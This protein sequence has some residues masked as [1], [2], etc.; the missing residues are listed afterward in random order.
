MVEEIRHYETSTPVG[1]A[2]YREGR[3]Y[4]YANFYHPTITI[5]LEI[6]HFYT[7]HPRSTL[8]SFGYHRIE[9]GKRSVIIICEGFCMRR[10][11][12]VSQQDWIW[13]RVN[14]L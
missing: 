6:C 5:V 11:S 12:R 8:C 7:R 10:V 13:I 4:W 14:E 9:W 2:K 3:I 1:L